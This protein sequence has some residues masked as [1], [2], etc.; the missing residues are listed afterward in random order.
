MTTIT[1]LLINVVACFNEIVTKPLLEGALDTFKKYSVKEEDIDR[2]LES[3][4]S[5]K[6]SYVSELW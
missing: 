6:P 1:N 4:E 3:Q 5:T 2:S